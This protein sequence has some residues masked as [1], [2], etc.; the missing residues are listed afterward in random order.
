MRASRIFA[1][2]RTMRW[3]SVVGAVRKALAIASVVSP[4]TSRSVERDLGLGRERRMA[5]GEDQPQAIV[6]DAVGFR[7]PAAIRLIVSS[8]SA[9]SASEASN[10]ARRRMASI[11]LKRPAETSHARGLAGTPSRCHCFD[12]GRKRVV[13]RLFGEVEIA[14]HADQRGQHAARFGAVD[15]VDLLAD[16]LGRVLAHLTVSLPRTGVNP[17]AVSCR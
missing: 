3:A 10:R 16:L 15:G 5:A 4:Q 2:A 11:A 14:Q 1:F 17:E 7:R 8:R 9:S 6:F 12:G 13:Q